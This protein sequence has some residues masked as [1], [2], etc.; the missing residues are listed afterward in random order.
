MSCDMWRMKLRTAVV[1]A[2]ICWFT[3]AAEASG[4]YGNSLASPSFRYSYVENVRK[5][6]VDEDQSREYMASHDRDLKL[7]FLGFQARA[8]KAI[9]DARKAGTPVGPYDLFL[10]AV[11]LR[12]PADVT[13]LDRKAFPLNLVLE[14][15][16]DRATASFEL[17]ATRPWTPAQITSLTTTLGKIARPAAVT[18]DSKDRAKRD[19]ALLDAAAFVSPIAVT[20][21][22]DRFG[23]YV[24]TVTEVASKDRARVVAALQATLDKLVPGV[25]TSIAAKEVN[26][27]LG[28]TALRPVKELIDKHPQKL[29]GAFH[30]WGP[31]V[32]G[33]LVRMSVSMGNVDA[34]LMIAPTGKYDWGKLSAELTT[35]LRDAGVADAHR[36]LVEKEADRLR[37]E[38]R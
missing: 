2:L 29:P 14:V 36:D 13:K 9:A 12:K 15:S 10:P 30:P 16:D 25:R 27:R 32:G 17:T 28:V 35:I 31:L 11:R 5:M 33:D 24:G 19:Q 8:E 23:L 37:G 21:V 20:H 26:T 34:I 3:G 4:A 22:D 38:D 1:V 18:D 6:F 7:R